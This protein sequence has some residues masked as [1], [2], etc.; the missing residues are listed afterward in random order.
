MSKLEALCE[1]DLDAEAL[2][3]MFLEIPHDQ[4]QQLGAF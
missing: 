4:R 1:G 3:R 2:D